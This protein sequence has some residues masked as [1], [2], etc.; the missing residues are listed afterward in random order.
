M[1]IRIRH[2]IALLLS[3]V[4][5]E[6]VGVYV[7]EPI[8]HSISVE[9]Y[10]LYF[11]NAIHII[12]ATEDLELALETPQN[13]SLPYAFNQTVAPILVHNVILNETTGLFQFNVTRGGEFYGYYVAEVKVCGP[14]MDVWKWYVNLA[15]ASPTFNVSGPLPASPPGVEKYLREPHE[16]VLSAVKPEFEK[17][18]EGSYGYGISNASKLGLAVAASYFVYHVFIQYDASPLPRTI[19]DVIKERKGDCDDMSRV[20][21]E[22]LNS[23]GI[24]ALIASGYDVIWQNFN[25]GLGNFHYVF[26]NNGPHSFAMAYI[27]GLGW[28]S[29]DLLAYSMIAYPFVFEGVYRETVVNQTEVGEFVE[30]HNKIWGSQALMALSEDEWKALGNIS[31]LESFINNTLSGTLTTTPA[32]T[33]ITQSPTPTSP[34]P[35]ATNTTPQDTRTS[36]ID[37][38]PM[39]KGEPPMASL[40]IIAAVL[41]LLIVIIAAVLRRRSR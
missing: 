38:A 33:P 4:V 20:L 23:Y 18:F 5:A 30:L 35:T 19:E 12:N 36:P 31:D 34:S 16:L 2:V 40:A 17:W 9:C 32:T 13:I 8:E 3:F 14:S 10:K 6:P 37:G 11:V 28:V 21:V 15:L 26:Y 27:D 24:P 25:I 39:Q 1:A 22:L 29:L 7:A 41:A